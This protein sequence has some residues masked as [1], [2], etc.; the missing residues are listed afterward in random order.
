[1]H[2]D[3]LINLHQILFE[4]KEYFEEIN[5]DLKFSQ[6]AALKITPAQ[7]HKSKV[8]HKHAIFVLGAEIANAMKDV[9]HTSSSRISAR[10]KE[11]AEKA[12]KEM[13]SL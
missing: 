10:M 12:L 2:K 13:E 1:M 8:E 11:L 3:E 5:P 7:Q 4:V 9:D 6:Y